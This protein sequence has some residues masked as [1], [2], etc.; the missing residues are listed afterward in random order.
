MKLRSVP[1]LPKNL[2]WVHS[3]VLK[4]AARNPKPETRNPKPETRNPKPENRNPKTENRN[5]SLKL[6]TRS[7]Q[8]CPRF[9]EVTRDPA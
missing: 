5:L 1:V 3:A 6:C 8:G 9:C 7:R 4:V 2:S